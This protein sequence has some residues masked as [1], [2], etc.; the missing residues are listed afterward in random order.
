MEEHAEDT[1][2]STRTGE[3]TGSGL[4]R[5]CA[6]WD[7]RDYDGLRALALPFADHPDYRAEW[8]I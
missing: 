8:K 1:Y 7:D 5:R 2:T 4:C 6:D 3:P